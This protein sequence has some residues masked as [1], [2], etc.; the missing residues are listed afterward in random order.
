MIGRTTGRQRHG[1]GKEGGTGTG[2]GKDTGYRGDG[3]RKRKRQRARGASRAEEMGPWE[4]E[5][6]RETVGGERAC[7][8]EVLR[9]RKCRLNSAGTGDWNQR[10]GE[11]PRPTLT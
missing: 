10:S 5:R 11:W 1:V 7:A 8:I 9:R 2:K 3:E 6:K 4:R